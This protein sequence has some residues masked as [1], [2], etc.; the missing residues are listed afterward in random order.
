MDYNILATILF[1]KIYWLLLV[2][3]YGRPRKAPKASQ[4]KIGDSSVYEVPN[5]N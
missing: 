2:K 3:G 1:T 4:P 5:M